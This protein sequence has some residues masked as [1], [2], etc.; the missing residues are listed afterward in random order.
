MRWFNNLVARTLPIVPKPI[1]GLFSRQYIAGEKLDDAVGAIKELM[2]QGMCATLDLLGEEVKQEQDSLK[3]VEIYKQILQA[4]DEEN[5]D[6]NIS[7]KPT[8][9]GL[10]IGKEFCYNNIKTLVEE[11][12]KINNFVRIDMEDS[13]CTDDT[14]EIYL[15]LLKDY[16]NVGTVLQSYMRRLMKDVNHLIPHKANLRLCKGAYYWEP[17]QVVYKDPDIINHSFI[18]ALEKLL[19]NRCY[20]GIATHDEKL[21]WAGLKLVDQLKLKP[22]EYEFQTLYGVDPEL[23]RIIVNA[24]HRLRVYVP[25]GKEWFAYSIRRLKENPK[26]VSYIFKNTFNRIFGIKQ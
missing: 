9:M 11:A 26:M 4:I 6:A 7:V 10:S 22:N 20:I 24:G 14:I 8:Q 16:S 13:C 23:R 15:R 3:A 17:R 2:S 25:F 18:Y 19:S 5:L 12:K 1:V 21:V